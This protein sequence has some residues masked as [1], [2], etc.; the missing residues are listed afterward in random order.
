M[1]FPLISI[2][3]TT[4]PNVIYHYC[5]LQGFQGIIEG[6]AIWLSDVRYCNDYM[7]HNW[8]KEKF[9][10]RIDY[11]R[12]Q[13]ASDFHNALAEEK[14]NYRE[15]LAFVACFSSLGD[16]LSQWRAYAED[17]AGFAIGFDPRYFNFSPSL[18]T[19][20]L[21]ASVTHGLLPVC[22]EEIEQ[23]R[24][25]Q[26]ILDDYRQKSLSAQ[27]VDDIRKVAEA[28]YFNLQMISIS[29]KN[30]AFKEE[31]EWRIVYRPMISRGESGLEVFGGNSNIFFRTSK[32]NLIPYFRLSFAQKSD[33]QSVKEV[34]LGPK[35]CLTDESGVF[36]WFLERNESSCGTLKQ[37]SVPYR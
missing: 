33:I 8:L 7:E 13:Q 27:S 31:K 36:S 15:H 14:A 2:P 34:I 12:S 22:Y 17:G 1:E 30:P 21:D 23:D 16:M 6:K 10:S 25:V 5:N 19:Y 29:C 26:R 20:G 18:P 24:L 35:R 32:H 9:D 11:L 3:N 28:C 37:S 4:M